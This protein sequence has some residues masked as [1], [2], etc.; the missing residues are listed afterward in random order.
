MSWRIYARRSNQEYLHFESELH[1]W[2]ETT[3]EYSRHNLS[4]LVFRDASIWPTIRYQCI[5]SVTNNSRQ[6]D[7]LNKGNL[8]NRLSRSF[9]RDRSRPECQVIKDTTEVR[10]EFFLDELS[11]KIGIEVF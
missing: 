4:E 1:L 2:T 10:L 6:L 3:A 8:I 5:E 7:V 11:V 9:V